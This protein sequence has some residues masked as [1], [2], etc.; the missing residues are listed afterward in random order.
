MVVS[1][2]SKNIRA[3]DSEGLTSFYYEANKTIDQTGVNEVSDY[4][5]MP[6]LLQIV[7]KMNEQLLPLGYKATVVDKS[8]LIFRTETH[9]LDSYYAW[10]I[11]YNMAIKIKNIS[12]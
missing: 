6:I 10:D 5:N 11:H 12:E 4:R 2:E 1:G 9:F 8:H 7:E 3:F